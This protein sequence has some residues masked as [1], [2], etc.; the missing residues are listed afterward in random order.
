M[1]SGLF[2]SK[3][4]LGLAVGLSLALPGAFAQDHPKTGSAKAAQSRG[5]SSG[6]DENIKHGRAANDPN[7]K[8][9]APPEKGGPKTRQGYCFVHIDN[10]TPYFAEIY[11]D[12]NYRGEIPKYG[13]LTGYVG[14]GNTNFYA[15]AAFTDGTYKTWGPSLY[16]VDGSFT[17]T[18]TF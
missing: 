6:P 17:W 1:K 18:L 16:Y 15:R 10:R 9:E 7:A 2:I 11:T 8:E 3:R 5:D 14:C 4:I 12:G 13:D